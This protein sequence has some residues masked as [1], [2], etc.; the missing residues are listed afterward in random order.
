MSKVFKRKTA[1][2]LS[3]FYYYRVFGGGKEKLRCTFQ[4]EL[5]AARAV[6]NGHTSA[7]GGGFNVDELFNA[8]L[9]R[10]DSMPQKDR[11]Q[12]RIDFGNRLLRLQAETLPFAEAWSKWMAMPNKSRHGNPSANTLTGYAAIWKRLE[13][14]AT[15]AKLVNL[16]EMTRKHGED[17]M[18]HLMA[19]KITARTYGAHLKFL[20]SMFKT[21]RLQAGIIEN[22]FAELT[23]PE[24]QTQSREAFTPEELK[25]I[26]EKATGDWRYLVGIGIYT[27]LR[28]TDAVHLKWGDVSDRIRV[29]PQK[30]KRRKKAVEIMLHPALAAL[31]DE[32]RR[33]RGGNPSGHL[34][35]ALVK[36]YAKARAYPSA[37]FVDFL[38]DVCGIQTTATESD[39]PRRRMASA[40][41][42]HSLRHSFVSM[43]AMAGVP[44][45]TTQKLVGHSS[46]AMTQIYSHTSDDEQ[47]KAINLLPSGFFEDGMNKPKP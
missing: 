2:G 26:C 36:E 1:D 41:G 30:T 34:F 32:L 24:L 20:R 8:L 6:A 12:R 5:K 15:A 17:Y 38:R 31:L 19:S 42:F 43:C 11:D 29:V 39:G 47:R 33:E 22:P 28:L 14:W 18:A 10:L 25:T 23:I 9:I 37:A 4:T 46:P 21:L 3:K 13:K 27:G 40:K 44:Q 16:H 45:A 7:V 35:P